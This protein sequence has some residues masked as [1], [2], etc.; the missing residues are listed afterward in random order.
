MIA[1]ANR[2]LLATIGA[3][4]LVAP[5]TARACPACYESL[6][7]KLL[8]SYYLSTV[9]LSVLPFAIVATLVLVGRSLRRRFGDLPVAETWSEQDRENVALNRQ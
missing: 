7:T 9:F 8:N 6:G 4:L 3:A 1:R 5:A 2:G